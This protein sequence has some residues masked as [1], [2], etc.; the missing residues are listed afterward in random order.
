MI[1]RMSHTKHPLVATDTAYG[2]T[3]LVGEGLECQPVVSGGQGARNGVTGALP[4]L[5][6]KETLDGFLKA[7]MQQVFKAAEGN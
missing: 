7:A 5:L 3:D 2:P 1:Q 4:V 6:S